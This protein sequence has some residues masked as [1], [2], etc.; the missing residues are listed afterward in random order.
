MSHSGAL[1]KF[2]GK[3]SHNLQCTAEKGYFHFKLGSSFKK[4]CLFKVKTDSSLSRIS[5]NLVAAA[6]TKKLTEEL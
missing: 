4:L 2:S 1:A 5:G 6:E 3:L